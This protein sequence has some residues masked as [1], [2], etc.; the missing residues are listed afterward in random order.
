MWKA[1]KYF[2]QLFLTSH[3][4]G[5]LLCEFHFLL[6]RVLVTLFGP[7]DMPTKHAE[8]PLHYN[9]REFIFLRCNGVNP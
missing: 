5:S 7:H 8:G 3:D 9:S 1:R 4:I 6:I 2:L